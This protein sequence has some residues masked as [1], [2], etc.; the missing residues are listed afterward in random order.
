VRLV[1]GPEVFMTIEFPKPG[2]RVFGLD[3]NI[4]IDLRFMRNLWIDTSYID[5]F[6]EAATVVAQ[7]L[8][9]DD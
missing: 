7:R 6:H 8:Q 9:T 4:D 2:D 3:G 5:G 1:I